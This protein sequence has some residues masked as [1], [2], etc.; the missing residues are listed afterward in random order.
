MKNYKRL[1]GIST[2]TSKV[3]KI[4]Q[5]FRKGIVYSDVNDIPTH[6]FIFYGEILGDALI[7]ESTDPVIRLAPLTKYINANKN[8]KIELYE[9]PSYIS[10]EKIDQALKELLSYIGAW[11]SFY[12]LLGYMWIWIGHKFGK[13]W[14][15]PV[16][17]KPEEAT[18]SDFGFQFLQKLEYQDPELMNMKINDIAPDNILKSMRKNCKLA[19][20]SDFK[21]E[22][23]TWSD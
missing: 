16:K 3:S 20:T 5:F 8:K 21:Q 18:C 14:H 12:Q 17:N 15:N 22:D 7:G 23:L 10:D 13:K 1:I 11:Y 2:G 4:I 19:A 6:I 9:L